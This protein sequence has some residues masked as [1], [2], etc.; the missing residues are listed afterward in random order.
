MNRTEKEQMVA[1]L[2]ADFAGVQGAV[3]A[4]YQGLT[5]GQ[6]MDIRRKFR[7]AGVQVK[8]IK[9]KLARIAADGTPL[10]VIKDD[11]VGPVALA[12]S[13]ED[14]VSPAKVAEKCAEE[15][16]KFVLKAGYCDNT[17]LD[18]P[19][20]EALAKLPGK[21]E[22]RSKFLNVLMAPGTNL[23]R[24]LNA[25]PQQVALVLNAYAKKQGEE[26]GE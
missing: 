26:G 21:D 4:Q 25:V 22:L 5:V 14:P 10:E 11:F 23:V 17:R 6:M 3:V 20:I 7:E 8:V 12:Y 9:N 1:D 16:E 19:G 15:Q 18:I 2:H 13:L 24:T